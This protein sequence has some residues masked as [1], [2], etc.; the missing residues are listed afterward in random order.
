MT[1][2]ERVASVRRLLREA[3]SASFGD[4]EDERLLRS[5]L[6][7]GYLEPDTTHI[8]AQRTLHLSRA[9]YFR[10][11]PHRGRTGSASTCCART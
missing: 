11:P 7:L 10:P 4:S 3:V 1:T 2:D 9:N 8:D 5:V 6:E